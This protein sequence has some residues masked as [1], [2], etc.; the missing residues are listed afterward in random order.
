MF[1]ELNK[2]NEYCFIIFFLFLLYVEMGDD[3][4]S[5]FGICFMTISKCNENNKKIISKRVDCWNLFIA[6]F[7]QTINTALVESQKHWD[8]MVI[9]ILCRI[10]QFQLMRWELVSL[11]I[12]HPSPPYFLLFKCVVTFDKFVACHA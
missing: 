8:A 4:M 1:N 7:F 12:I 11:L 6:L 10:P 2:L 5:V 3:K 9:L